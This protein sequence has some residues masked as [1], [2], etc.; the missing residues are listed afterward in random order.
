MATG[1][2]S[3]RSATLAYRIWAIATPRGWDLTLRELADEL[4]ESFD[5]VRSIC[6][7]KGWSGRLRVASPDG[8]IGG[9]WFRSN[10]PYNAEFGVGEMA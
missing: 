2:L 7:H 8:A 10:A 1:R 9:V 5:R 6:M 3:P 4:G